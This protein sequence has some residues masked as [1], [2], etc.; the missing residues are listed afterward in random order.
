MKRCCLLALSMLAGVLCAQDVELQEKSPFSFGGDFRLRFDSKDNAPNKHSQKADREDLM[1]LR[2][3]LYGK[4]EWENFDIKVQLGNEFRYYSEPDSSK[5]KQRFPDQTFFDELYFTVKGDWGKLRV[6][7]QYMSFGAKRIISDGTGADGSRSGFFD[8]ARLTLDLEN[9]RTLDIF[10][11]FMNEEDWLPTIGHTHD[12]RSAD[13]KS[14]DVAY[15]GYGEEYGLG[16]YYTDKSN[17]EFP[18]EAYAV[19][20]MED[21]STSGTRYKNPDG[22]PKSLTYLTVGTRLCP[23]FTDHLSGEL[24]IAGQVGQDDLSAMMAYAGLTYAWGGDLAPKITAAVQYMSGDEDGQ[25]GESAWHSVFNRGTV[26]GDLIDGLY[27]SNN[28]TNII[29]PHAAFSFKPFK[30]H[31]FD[32]QA[33]PMFAAAEEGNYGSYMGIFSQVKY[34]IKFGKYFNNKYLESLA[35]NF[36]GEVLTKDEDYFGDNDKTALFGRLEFTYSF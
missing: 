31:S 19:L 17:K 21:G 24:E 34:G 32:I 25:N 13:T 20:K 35:F 28:Y 2:T 4:A 12:A 26:I 3:H 5:G 8:A 10:A 11:T 6:G 36:K 1:R 16:A 7:R 27:S 9:K 30:N 15:T 18:W 33:G 23:K 29:Y 14:Y 22:T